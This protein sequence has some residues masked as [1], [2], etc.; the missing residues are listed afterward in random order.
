MGFVKNEVKYRTP[1]NLSVLRLAIPISVVSSNI[2]FKVLL[3]S[4]SW[5]CILNHTTLHFSERRIQHPFTAGRFSPLSPVIHASCHSSVLGIY[6]KLKV[7]ASRMSVIVLTTKRSGSRE[8]WDIYPKSKVCA[9]HASVG[10]FT[11]KLKVCVM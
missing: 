3:C 5:M 6:H 2:F 10:V 11:P 9:T 1:V 4:C 7:C 8:C